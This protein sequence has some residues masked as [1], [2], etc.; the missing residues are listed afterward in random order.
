M[1]NLVFKLILGTLLAPMTPMRDSMTLNLFTLRW[2]GCL[3]LLILDIA[4]H[5][6]I[7][8]IKQILQLLSIE[9]KIRAELLLMFDDSLGYFVFLFLVASLG[10]HQ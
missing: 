2:I 4:R 5:V 3:N 1:F 10:Q 7:R 9:S 8:P 6:A